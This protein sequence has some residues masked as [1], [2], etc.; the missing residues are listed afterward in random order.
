MTAA[1]AGQVDLTTTIG[2]VRLANPVMTASG[3]AGNGRELGRFC[4]LAEVGAFVSP[5][6]T[7]DGS[8]GRPLPRVVE[9]PSGLL[10]AVGLA[11][12]GID[13]FLAIDLPWLLRN[14]IRPIVS[15]AG[16]NLGEYAELARRVGNTPGIAGVEVNLSSLAADPVQASRAVSVVR[17]D[18][19][20][21]VP[22]L[23]KLWPGAAMVVEMAA[24]VRESGAD[25]V[26]LPGSLPGLALDLGTLR[27][28][29]G[30]VTGDLTGPAL[31]TVGLYAV[32]QVRRAMPGACIVGSGGIRSG[33]DALEYLAAGA[34]AVQVGSACFAD[35]S[36]AVRVADELRRELAG[37]GFRSAAS[38]V[39]VAHQPPAPRGDAQP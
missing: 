36:A 38:A 13:A 35:P 1:P 34:N 15:I 14:D 32:W 30:G 39:G 7:R 24:A 37:R 16:A 8:G 6:V 27:P 2:D 23:A 17:R 28:V 4:D 11:G 33:A 18:T 9:T 19:A 3:C 26:V 20:A 21:G 22:V 10:N 31:K 5:S 25:A 12:A 29:L